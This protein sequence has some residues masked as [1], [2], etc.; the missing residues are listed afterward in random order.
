MISR[1]F[2]LFFFLFTFLL[3]DSASAQTTSVQV[4]RHPYLRLQLRRL[5]ATWEIKSYKNE[6]ILY[7]P[8][9]EGRSF[10]GE[11]ISIN[12][13]EIPAGETC[14]T[15]YRRNVTEGLRE[16]SDFYSVIERDTLV[17][18]KTFKQNVFTF[19]EDG[20]MWKDVMCTI[21]MNN[22]FYI[23]LLTAVPESYTRHLEVFWDLLFFSKPD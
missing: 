4:Y 14:N 21:C 17:G 18:G 23:F 12:G 7:A 8:Y 19:R 2:G 11:N 22:R 5:P 6:I 10:E 3:A 13:F 20:K 1:T 15:V 9:E 16:L